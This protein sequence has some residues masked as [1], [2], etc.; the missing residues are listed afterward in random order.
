MEKN[1]LQIQFI[2]NSEQFSEWDFKQF[3]NLSIKYS[4]EKCKQIVDFENAGLIIRSLFHLNFFRLAKKNIDKIKNGNS[5]AIILYEGEVLRGFM[6]GDIDG[7][8]EA[9]ITGYYVDE[10]NHLEARRISLELYKA[11]VLELK[12]RNVQTIVARC[13]YHENKFIDLL[14][15]LEFEHISSSTSSVKYGYRIKPL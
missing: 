8:K 12:K 14:E 9:S 5:M 1:K 3:Q 15:T 2:K 6:M 11:F 13:R 7:W 4:W 10:E